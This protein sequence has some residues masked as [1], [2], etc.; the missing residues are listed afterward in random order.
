VGATSGIIEKN[1]DI[2][3]PVFLEY[4]TVSGPSDLVVSGY[5]DQVRNVKEEPGPLLE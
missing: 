4:R 5:A 2:S 1:I 3:H